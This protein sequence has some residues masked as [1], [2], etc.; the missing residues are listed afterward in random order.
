MSQVPQVPPGGPGRA[1]QSTNEIHPK[2]RT[3]EKFT[4]LI[5]EVESTDAEKQGKRRQRPKVEEEQKV[6]EAEVAFAPPDQ[7]PE[8]SLISLSIPEFS[9]FSFDRDPTIRGL[10]TP[11]EGRA[12]FHEQR[13]RSP[14]DEQNQ[15]T[16]PSGPS[17]RPSKRARAGEPDSSTG[18]PEQSVAQK[19][20]KTTSEDAEQ[21][22]V[23]K[24]AVA[25]RKSKNLPEQEMVA[26]GTM[27]T[28]PAKKKPA[29]VKQAPSQPVVSESVPEATEEAIVKAK[30]A[31][32]PP[33]AQEEA[34][35][36]VVAKKRKS[37]DAATS[38]EVAELV[39]PGKSVS[40]PTTVPRKGAPAESF[41]TPSIAQ[42]IEAP[43]ESAST[44][45]IAQ[46]IEA[47]EESIS[48]K[49]PGHEQDKT[50]KKEAA[51]TESLAPGLPYLAQAA[52][53]H[54]STVPVAHG[55]K[56][57]ALSGRPL[58]VVELQM[59]TGTGAVGSTAAP[60]LSRSAGIERV[61]AALKA[62]VLTLEQQTDKRTLTITLKGDPRLAGTALDGLKI[63][64]EEFVAAPKQYNITMESSPEAQALLSGSAANM[65][66][67]LNRLGRERGWSVQR[68]DVQVGRPLFHRKE[69][70]DMR[71]GAGGGRGGKTS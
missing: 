49:Q 66:D 61:L 16:G 1:P 63:S 57:E 68:L 2:G 39:T 37:K 70:S 41:S 20:K 56:L 24:R 13:A 71:G 27:A 21:S 18:A 51:T 40:T 36:G 45:S 54:V 43:E 58:P 11:P 4:R 7:A 5:K 9:N 17:R 44:P 3:T 29:S 34:A 12:S 69:A 59:R 19:R 52:L 28:P 46:A 6:P 62:A 14:S 22:L 67:Q 33:K 8:P 25:S 53:H 31:K 65:V 15:R 55:S 48:T 47:P 30:A 35:V 32:G 64:V 50:R 38:S 10:E 42:A 23:S 60:T 26:A